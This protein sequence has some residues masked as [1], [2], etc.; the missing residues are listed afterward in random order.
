MSKEEIVKGLR[1]IESE[2]SDKEF[3]FKFVTTIE[4]IVKENQKLSNAINLCVKRMNILRDEEWL[5]NQCW[6]EIMETLEQTIKESEKN[7]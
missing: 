2:V 6:L 3:W 4:G 1:K 7:E 5:S